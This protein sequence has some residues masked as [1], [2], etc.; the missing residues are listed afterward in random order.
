[1]RRR[2]SLLLLSLPLFGLA[3]FRTPNS[4]LQT[5]NSQDTCLAF[6]STNLAKGN[7]NFY[8]YEQFSEQRLPIQAGDTL[9]YS[10]LL[11]QKNPEPKGGVDMDFTDNGD[12]LRDVGVADQNGIRAHGDGI[13]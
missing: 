4:K 11:D 8:T 13:L 1:M 7:G 3:A 9:V 6:V 2:H 10:V 5:P 12:A